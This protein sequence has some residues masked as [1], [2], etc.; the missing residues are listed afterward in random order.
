[1]KINRIFLIISIC[2]NCFLVTNSQNLR[3]LSSSKQDSLITLSKELIL[4]FGPDYYREYKKPEISFE[5]FPSIRK[6]ADQRLIKLADRY[7]YRVT[8]PYDMTQ[9]T[10]E[11]PYAAQVDIWADT[12]EPSRVMFGC[13][14]GISLLDIK[15]WRNDNTIE[16]IEY[17]EISISPIYD[18]S[19]SVPDSLYEKPEEQI[20][21]Y[22]RKF[23]ELNPP[24]PTNKDE[25]IKR[26]WEKRSD[27]EWVKVRSDIP[28]NKR[29]R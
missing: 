4:R 22:R 28:P 14:I 7:F 6:I 13:G 20:E 10:F 24:E 11:C 18:Y 9:E 3:I 5:Q 26:G 12:F 25:L 15:D 2:M 17:Q 23:F 8:F 16:P 19:I 27:G 29:K 1:M 21:E